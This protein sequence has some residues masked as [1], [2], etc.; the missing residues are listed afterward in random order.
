M[1]LSSHNNNNSLPELESVSHW[2]EDLQPLCCAIATAIAILTVGEAKQ[3]KQA[4]QP[5]PVIK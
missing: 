1:Q 2:Y 3:S 4:N 5:H